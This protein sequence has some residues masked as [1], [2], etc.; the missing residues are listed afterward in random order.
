[1]K[2][3]ICT[4]SSPAAEQSALLVERLN[5]PG[6][7]DLTMLGVIDEAGDPAG[8]DASFDRMTHILRKNGQ[9]INH[10]VRQGNSYEQILAEAVEHSYDLVAVGV[11]GQNQGLL[12]FKVGSTTAKLA[13]KLHTHFLVARS[14]PEKV[15][16]ILVCTGAEAPSVE[17]MQV[18]GKMIS[19][20]QADVAVLHVVSQISLK[21]GSIPDEIMVSAK[22]A[23]E[24]Q[25]REGQ[26]LQR[27]IQQLAQ[28]GVKSNI[29]P[30]MRHGLVVDEVLGEAR[31]GNYDLMVVGAHYQ[32]G[33]NRWLG[34]LLDDV[35][36]QLL[37]QSLCSVL[38][39]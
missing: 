1:M 11:G 38:I 12:H 23:I 29:V 13:R 31:E 30:R 16:K 18:G 32:P 35:T 7:V 39:I 5:I 28:A 3:L 15:G 4:D 10:L 37:N 34:I 24:R 14:V 9:T 22:T 19:G 27:A 8:I 2:V 21:P 20:L 6:E 33:Q 36:D 25:T 17:T 26:H